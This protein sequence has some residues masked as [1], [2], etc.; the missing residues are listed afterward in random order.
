MK[1]SNKKRSISEI[2]GT[3]I[4]G[5]IL[6]VVIFGNG[7]EKETIEEGFILPDI[8]KEELAPPRESV[9]NDRKLEPKEISFQWEYKN[10]T[11]KLT[12]TFYKT[13][14]EDW[15]SKQREWHCPKEYIMKEKP[16]QGMCSLNS[17]RNTLQLILSN[18]EKDEMISK[19]A[20]DIKTEG[21]KRRLN[22]DQIVE[23]AV[24]FVQSIP[25]DEDYSGFHSRYPYEVLYEKKGI[26]LGKSFLAT[27]LIKELGYGTA[28]LVYSDKFSPI[29]EGHMAVGIK[30]PEAKSSYISKGSFYCY[31]ETTQP[32]WQIGDKPNDNTRSLFL[33]LSPV[34]FFEPKI[35][36]VSEGKTYQGMM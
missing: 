15:K 6:L 7:E 3:I 14:Y 27:L 1:E 8:S 32:G 10:S 26:C 25:Y 35:F 31:T 21:G 9:N 34:S 16:F 24:A 17:E 5:V 30:C 36:K 2:I 33:D 28:L 22:S 29:R 23:L 13:D 18:A 12:E 11:Y 20:L 4:I 19:I